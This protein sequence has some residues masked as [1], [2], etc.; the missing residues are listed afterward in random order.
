MQVDDIK[1]Y[2]WKKAKTCAHDFLES[3][4]FKAFEDFAVSKN[5]MI[6]DAGCGGGYTTNTLFKEGFKNIFGFDVSDSGI[7]VAKESFKDI[8][9]RIE[10]HNGYNKELP[11]TFPKNNNYDLILSVEV[12]EHLFSPQ[13]YLG[14]CRDWL[15]DNG[16][17]IIT[18]PYHGYLKNLAIAASNGFDRH[19]DPLWEGG[20][21]KFFSRKTL[22]K[23]LEESGFKPL[24][25]YGSG[26][27][28]YLWKAMVIVARRM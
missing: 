13:K 27:V 8:E 10:I 7:R 26:R 12:M 6:L 18:T 2:G 5:A 16:L 21:I 9:D 20:H 15:G 23:L 11:T 17:I 25:F 1:D 14:N 4:I 3:S 19:V 24:K 28:P 22:Q